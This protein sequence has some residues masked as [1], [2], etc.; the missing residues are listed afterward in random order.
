MIL[1]EKD[2]RHL[3]QLFV[4]FTMLHSKFRVL[5]TAYKYSEIDFNSEIT[6]NDY[7]A[8]LCGMFTKLEDEYIDF[9]KKFKTIMLP[10]VNDD[11]IQGEQEK[12]ELMK[13]SETD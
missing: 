11:I 8:E 7:H 4:D 5:T 6:Y 2:E 9:Y 10:V 13:A 12:N 3:E 1:T